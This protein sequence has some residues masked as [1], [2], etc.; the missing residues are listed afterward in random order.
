MIYLHFGCLWPTSRDLIK[1]ICR[2]KM[3]STKDRSIINFQY[4]YQTSAYSNAG[5][6]GGSAPQQQYYEYS[7]VSFAVVC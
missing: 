6:Y 7:N 5:M 2:F 4:E 3:F 1:I